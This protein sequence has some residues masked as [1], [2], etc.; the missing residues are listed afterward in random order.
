MKQVLSALVVL[1]LAGVVA[2]EEK[3]P[4]SLPALGIHV[5]INVPEVQQE[6]KLKE[7]QKKALEEIGTEAR[8]SLRGV[9][10]LEQAERQKK[11]R[12]V[13]ENAEAKLEKTLNKDQ[14]QR[15]RQIDL[16]Q[17]GPI[18]A[19]RKEIAQKLELTRE[20]KQKLREISQETTKAIQKL[21][22]DGIRRAE[23][24]E[25]G[26]KVRAAA[27]AKAAA[28]LTPEQKKLWVEMVGKRFD[29]SKIQAPQ[30]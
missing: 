30:R 7:D 22:E 29:V 21:R 3:K 10:K 17:H 19:S 12:E 14:L 13:R 9:R 2:A 15:L 6:L 5:L 27:A 23:L 11:F 18:V 8:Q 24:A 28:V 20:Q 25:K 16:Q 26:G 1:F 4:A